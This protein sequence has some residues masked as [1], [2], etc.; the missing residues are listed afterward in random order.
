[1][2]GAFSRGWFGRLRQAFPGAGVER[3][4][5]VKIEIRGQRWLGP[6]EMLRVIE[7]ESEGRRQQFALWTSRQGGQMMPLEV[8]SA[9]SQGQAV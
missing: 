4:E 3:P 1:M 9:E 5:A 7:I 2:T 6:G 8:G